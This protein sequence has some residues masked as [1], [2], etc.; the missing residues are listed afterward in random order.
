MRREDI[1]TW[2]NEFPITAYIGAVSGSGVTWVDIVN[3]AGQ[4][5]TSLAAGA[6]FDCY[7]YFN[8]ANPD[9]GSWGV[10]VTVSAADGSNQHYTAYPISGTS[11]T[12][13]VYIRDNGSIPTPFIMP[14][15]ALSL[16]AICWV[17]PAAL[18]SDVVAMF[19]AQV[20]KS[21]WWSGS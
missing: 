17:Y 12:S 16:R 11:V 10:A 7:V 3:A 6:Y 9:G 20:P 15:G 14:S 1:V 19:L 18:T 8:A 21:K 5:V 2:G 4:I 13:A